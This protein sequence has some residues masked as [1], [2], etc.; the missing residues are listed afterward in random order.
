[1]TVDDTWQ[2]H[3][4]TPAFWQQQSADD[5]LFFTAAGYR[6][7]GPWRIGVRLEQTG[8]QMIVTGLLLL[9]TGALARDDLKGLSL[10]DLLA[11]ARKYEVDQYFELEDRPASRRVGGSHPGR[12][13]YDEQHDEAFATDYREARNRAA[14][15]NEA[16]EWLAPRWGKHPTTLYRWIDRCVRNGLL[17]EEE[18]H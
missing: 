7:S 8:G 6:G 5:W 14:S 9:G 15:K 12:R 3:D 16:V 1:M 4:L 11:L 17:T 13:G 10:E 18:A 2:A